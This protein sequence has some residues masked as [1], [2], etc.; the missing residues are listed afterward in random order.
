MLGTAV[1]ILDPRSTLLVSHTGMAVVSGDF[2]TSASVLRLSK[3]ATCAVVVYM[4]NPGVTVKVFT[5]VARVR[6]V[7]PFV[8]CNL[9]P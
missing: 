7:R 1:T 4:R 5:F 6:D 2:R 9:L 3:C 8:T